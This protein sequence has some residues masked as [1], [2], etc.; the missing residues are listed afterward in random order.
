M[1]YSVFLESKCWLDDDVLGD[2]LAVVEWHFL[3]ARKVIGEVVEDV[4]AT[5]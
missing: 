4:K 3:G 5:H 1:V 2:D